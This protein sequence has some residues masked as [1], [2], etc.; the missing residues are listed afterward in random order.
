M[1]T[2]TRYDAEWSGWKADPRL[3]AGERRLEQVCGYVERLRPKLLLDLGCGDGRFARLI[4]AACPGVTV[5]GCDVSQAA[6]ARTEGVDRAYPL[7]LDTQ[8]LPE[9][10]GSF[11]V[12][13]ASEVIEHLSDPRHALAEV[14]RVLRPAGRLLVTV[15]NV[16]FWRYRVQLLRGD[17]PSVTADERHLH[18]YNAA[19]LRR[20]LESEGFMV[21]RITGLRRRLDWLG[22]LAF[23]LLCDSLLA[24]AERP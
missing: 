16:A 21:L 24:E 9:A 2:R 13:T 22:R 17:V 23:T 12:V 15:P 5:H 20:L 6:L 18:S 14:K 4:K 10:G 1:S 7:D 3:F 19:S 11:D 8:A